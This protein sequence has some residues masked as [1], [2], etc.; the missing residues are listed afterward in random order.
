MPMVAFWGMMA[1]IV[2]AVALAVLKCFDVLSG[3]DL[4][5]WPVI[6]VLSLLGCFIGTYTA[7]P[8]S[9]ETTETLFTKR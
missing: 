5:Y 9:D 8:A 6:F 2:P 7:P 4:Y 1:G 3:L